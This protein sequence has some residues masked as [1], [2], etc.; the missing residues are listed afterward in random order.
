[1]TKRVTLTGADQ[2]IIAESLLK[3]YKESLVNTTA[4][5][6]RAKLAEQRMVQLFCKID[7]APFFY[8]RLKAITEG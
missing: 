1:M 8:D 6:E 3:L 4:Y 5:P 2:D 7:P